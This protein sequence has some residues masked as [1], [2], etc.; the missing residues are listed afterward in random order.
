[1]SD[2]PVVGVLGRGVPLELVEATGARPVRLRGDVALDTG[3]ADELLGRGIDPAA[4]AVLAALLHDGFAGLR[5][6]VVANDSEASLRVYFVLREL[7]RVEPGAGVPPLHLLDVAH[8]DRAASRAYTRAEFAD[9]A[10]VL[11][12]W[13]GAAFD[14][15]RLGAVIARREDARTSL[16]ALRAE[17]AGS[18]FLTARLAVDESGVLERPEPVA[19]GGPRL[20]LSG[21]GHDA[22]DVTAAIESAGARLVGDDHPDGELGLALRSATP[23]LD[24][25]ADRY[26]A[27]G[28]TSH[29]ASPRE[30]A[31]HLARLV[32]ERK[33]D[34]VL[35]YVRRLDDAPLWDVAAQRAAVD[36]PVVV[37]SGQEYGRIDADA[38]D[39]A[40]AELRTGAR[41]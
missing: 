2:A 14:G 28:P 37:V 39:A 3:G 22:P 13:T 26:A 33:A 24:G 36:V 18:T 40:L 23:D 31:E 8:L 9:T 38:L 27:D 32:A 6:I 7:A 5:G 19:A 29:R 10:A 30:R 12:E 1:M 16:A 11:A 25:L 20:I 34:G 15:D 17:V 21:S 41:R 4:N 35:V